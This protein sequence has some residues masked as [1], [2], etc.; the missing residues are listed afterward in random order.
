MPKPC[1]LTWH[2]L[3]KSLCILFMA[4][5]L[6]AKLRLRCSFA[7]TA[8]ILQMAQLK[9]DVESESRRSQAACSH[10]LNQTQWTGKSRR[11]PL[12]LQMAC[13]A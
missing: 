1:I 11:W 8:I 10:L 3:M 6:V 2:A 9:L 12:R 5:L 7:A 4:Q 13:L